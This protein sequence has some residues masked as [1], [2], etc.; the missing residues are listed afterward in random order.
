M[1]PPR[2]LLRT[3]TAI[4]GLCLL[5]ASAWARQ[6]LPFRIDPEP[7]KVDFAL[8]VTLNGPTNVNSDAN[9]VQLGFPC[10]SPKTS[11]DPGLTFSLARTFG[12]SFGVAGEFSLYHNLFDAYSAS[13]GVVRE[14]NRVLA[15]AVGPRLSTPYIETHGYGGRPDYV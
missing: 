7:P 5:P 14:D 1:F 11:P 15:L 9:C 6:A 12:T 10:S 2:C 8:G 13:H 4:A 3:F